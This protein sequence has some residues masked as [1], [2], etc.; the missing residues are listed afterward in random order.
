M[1]K[2][3]LAAAI[4]VGASL[5]GASL[6]AAPA[7][8]YPAGKTMTVSLDVHDNVGAGS[9]ISARAFNV[10]PG[11]SVNFTITTSGTAIALNRTVSSV[12]G[13]NG[14]TSLVKLKAPNVASLYK[15]TASA[16]SCS[17]MAGKKTAYDSI[18]V[19]RLGGGTITLTSNTKSAAKKPTLTVSGTLTWGLNFIENHRGW[20]KV[21]NSDGTVLASG[22][23][24]TSSKGKFSF[25]I[26]PRGLKAGRYT[27]IATFGADKVYQSL[28]VTSLL[29]LTK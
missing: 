23:V 2:R 18:R 20:V 13:A 14:N 8:A 22:P 24:T 16:A 3:L 21:A 10:L 11:C 25:S 6:S 1:K 19:G 12:A 17:Q 15:V 9:T 26:K 28:R 5:I 7:Q 29:T 27:A 4:A